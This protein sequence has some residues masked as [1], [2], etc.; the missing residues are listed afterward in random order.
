MILKNSIFPA[1][2]TLNSLPKCNWNL[3]KHLTE[4][5][6]QLSPT[7]EVMDYVGIIMQ[8]TEKSVKGKKEVSMTKLQ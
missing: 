7:P 6:L 5:T 1:K 4:F 3:L 2:Q 8:V